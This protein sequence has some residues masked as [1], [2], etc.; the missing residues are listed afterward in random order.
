[1]EMVAE[2]LEKVLGGEADFS[3]LEKITHEECLR[4]GR[5]ALKAAL[6]ALDDALL[7]ERPKGLRVVGKRR[8]SILTLLGEVSFERRYY[9]DEEGNYRF[10]LDELLRVEKGRHLSPRM[11]EMV[12]TLSTYIPYRA[13]EELLSSLSSDAP[14]HTTFMKETRRLGEGY[15][16]EQE[17][18]AEALFLHGSLP[19][20]EGRRAEIL[21]L[22][23]DGTMVNLQ[24]EERRRGELKLAIAH[25]GWDRR[26]DGEYAL[27]GKRVHM[28]MNPS[29]AFVRTQIYDL[30]TRW[31]L[32][33]VSRF[34]VGGDG[35]PLAREA[36]SLAPRSLFQ[37]DRFHLRRAILRATAPDG[38]L[39]R[40][41]YELSVAGRLE[42]ALLL[43]K[44]ERRRSE[45][46]R[47]REIGRLISYLL[48]NREGLLDFRERLPEVGAEARGLGAVEGNVD[49][50]VANRFKK[51]GRRFTLS[52]AHSLAKV[53]ELRINGNLAGYLA[54]RARR[55]RPEGK[56]REVV[57]ASAPLRQRISEDPES[58]LRVHMPV[59]Y[60][61]HS[62][63][64]WVKVLRGMGRL[65]KAV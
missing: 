3:S 36:A 56:R 5:E 54:E 27:R 13:A 51:R 35:A 16:Q 1:M 20:T 30:S 47:G 11:Q 57:E 52:G 59:L 53:V 7:E 50:C 4:A 38:V 24:G 29:S 18:G 43:L 34:V 23:L 48:Q 2:M 8:R 45:P 25:E 33:S 17:E 21:Y 60:G 12:A 9:R 19:E 62:D 40:R 42:E 32:S 41:V 63:E 37:L 55:V 61:P 64:P 6:E 46:R 26:S 44:E 22:E 10:L 65:A 31:D 39:S 28:G 58:W 14:S 15:A 49:K